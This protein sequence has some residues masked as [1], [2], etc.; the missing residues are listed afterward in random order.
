MSTVSPPSPTPSPLHTRVGSH[1]Q[2]ILCTP[3]F[4]WQPAMTRPLE[5]SPHG[6]QLRDNR[7]RTGGLAAVNGDKGECRRASS[8][9]ASCV[10]RSQPA[11]AVMSVLRC[12]M[13]CCP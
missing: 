8:H 10:E 3:P 12:H 11:S 5:E 13:C 4:C 6:A 2:V 1:L 7:C 9:T